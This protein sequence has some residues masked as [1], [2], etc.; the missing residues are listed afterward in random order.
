MERWFGSPNVVVDEEDFVSQWRED[1][2]N[3]DEQ[4]S[5]KLFSFPVSPGIG[6][7]SIRGTETPMDRLGN[8]QLYIGSVLTQLVRGLMPFS[9]LWDDSYD[10]LL[11]T[12]SWVA[13]DHLQQSDYYRIT[14]EFVNDLLL[15]DYSP[16]PNGKR[17]DWLRTTGVSLGGGLALITG[18]QTDAYAFAF[19]GPNPTLARKTW[20]PPISLNNLKERVI[21]IKPENDFV[22]SIGDVVPNYQLVR[23]RDWPAREHNCHSFWRIFCEYM[24]TCGSPS[25][26]QMVACCVTL[27][28]HL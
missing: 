14:T 3:A 23:C 28:S 10:D 13:S 20:D 21:N 24:Y 11:L 5:F 22:S 16:S 17:F 8:A 19:S 15:N 26:K 1:S 4:V 25:G 18:A 27:S 12:T 9:W 6:I 2:G 7:L